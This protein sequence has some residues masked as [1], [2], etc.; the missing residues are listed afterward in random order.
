ME[1]ACQSFEM[2]LSAYADAEASPRERAQVEMHLAACAG[3]RARLEDLKALSAAVS[4]HLDVQADQADFSRFA[5]EVFKRIGPE[6]P[7]LLERARIWWSEILA[8]HRTAVISSLATAAVTVAIAVPL[9]WRLA[10]QNASQINP[11][12]VLHQ[13]RLENPALQPVVMDMGDG[14]TLIMLVDQ[15]GSGAGDAVPQQLDTTPPTGGD[16]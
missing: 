6:A 16:L 9:V 8:Y 10:S 12:V 7:G 5:D 11:Q 15:S 13:L 3:C 1:S 4:G 14:R 2:L